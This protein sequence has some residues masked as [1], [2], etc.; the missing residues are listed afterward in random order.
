[1]LLCLGAFMDLAPLILIT[2]PILMPVVTSPAI[3]MDPIHFGIVMLFNL[4]LGL[5]TPPLGTVLFVGSGI[6]GLKVETLIKA[7]LPFYLVMI[8]VLILLTFIPAISMTIPNM[9][10]GQ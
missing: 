3:G 8:A 4:S 6:S 1:M 5:M 2:A 7:M 9:M 10:F